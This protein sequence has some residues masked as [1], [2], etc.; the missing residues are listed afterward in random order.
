VFWGCLWVG[1]SA[2]CHP[3]RRSPTST[4]PSSPSSPP[5]PFHD[6]RDVGIRCLLETG[7]GKALNG[8]PSDLSRPGMPAP[9]LDSKSAPSAFRAFSSPTGVVTAHPT[10]PF[11]PPKPSSA[12]HFWYKSCRNGMSA[13]AQPSRFIV[14]PVYWISKITKR[15]L[16][17][18]LSSHAS[19]PRLK[20]LWHTHWPSPQLSGL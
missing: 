2:G 20:P 7:S 11:H 15:R 13:Y 4:S 10:S 3:G 19:S 14:H 17:C 6:P 18:L 12:L 9:A 8:P 1:R 16:L 5:P